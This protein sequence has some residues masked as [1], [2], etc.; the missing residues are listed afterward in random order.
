MKYIITEKQEERI[1]VLRRTEEDWLWIQQIVDEG[2]DIDDPC[3][4]NNKEIYLNRVCVDSAN[5]YLYNYLDYVHD[6]TFKILSSFIQDLIKKRMGR[7]II[8]Y[9]EEKREEC[10]ENGYLL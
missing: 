1:K 5:T 4:F 3:D 6:E 10:D 8:K 9:W 7:D 2:I